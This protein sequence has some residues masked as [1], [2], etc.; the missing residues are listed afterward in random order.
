ML[1]D[2]DGPLWFKHVTSA[3]AIGDASKYM[4]LANKDFRPYDLSITSIIELEVVPP[5]DTTN[6]FEDDSLILE[7]LQM[8]QSAEEV[9]FRAGV[10]AGGPS[11][12]RRCA[13]APL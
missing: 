1:A 11:P 7:S 12:R 2:P 9:T 3:D 4:C 13:K 6:N 5:A 10:P 8:F